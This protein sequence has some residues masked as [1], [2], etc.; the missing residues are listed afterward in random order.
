VRWQ[1]AA[2]ARRALQARGRHAAVLLCR[3]RGVARRQRADAG[4]WREKEAGWA[5]AEAGQR[6]RVR[7]GGAGRM[8]PWAEPEAAAREGRKSIF[9]F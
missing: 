9:D 4:E 7:A 1:A 3:D 5:W 2:D 6:G 8:W